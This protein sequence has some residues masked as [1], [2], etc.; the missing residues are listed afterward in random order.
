M[1]NPN[2]F[3]PPRS[4]IDD[5][6][7]AKAW[8]VRRPIP[9]F[10]IA[11]FCIFQY[12]VILTELARNWS[13]YVGLM[14]RGLVSPIVFFGKLAYPTLLFAAGVALLFLWRRTAVVLFACYLATGLAR[15]AVATPTDYFSLAIVFGFFV[16]SL[17]I[18]AGAKVDG[19][20]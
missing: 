12:Y 5:P 11:A 4:R 14:D 1:N 13:G 19:G 20:N 15:I 3:A 18:A 7:G 8:F 2:P 6:R 17:R 16:Y 9:V 10:V